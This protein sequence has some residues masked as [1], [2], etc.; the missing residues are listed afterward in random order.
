M[1]HTIGELDGNLK[2]SPIL[3]NYT[4]SPKSNSCQFKCHIEQLLLNSFCLFQKSCI[5]LIL[6]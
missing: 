4:Y 2:I 5:N 1:T 3:S 6:N